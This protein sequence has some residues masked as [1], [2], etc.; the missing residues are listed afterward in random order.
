VVYDSRREHQRRV[1]RNLLFYNHYREEVKL[2]K[3]LWLGLCLIAVLILSNFVVSAK[4][5]KTVI[6]FQDW[7][8]TET[9]WLQCLK[10]VT[11]EYEKSHP[12]VE[13]Q[14][15]PVSQADKAKKFIIASEANNAPDVI[16]CEIQDIPP[17]IT[18]GYL[19]NLN[20]LIQKEKKG[21][22]DQWAE[23]PRKIGI[24]RG[25]VR[26][27]PDDAQSMVI[28]YNPEIFKAAGLDPNKPPKTWEEFREY[29]K[30][31]TNGKDQWGFG[32]VANKS[33]SLISRYFP[34][35]W[36]FGGDIF[37]A[38][39]T[40]C[41]LDSP[42]SIQAFKYFVELYTKDGVTPPAP[43]EMS[44]QDVRTFMAQKKIGMLIGSGFTISIVDALNP[45]LKAR[46]VLRVAP[47]PVGKKNVTFAQIDFWG[48]SR[49]TKIK[50]A[51]WDWIKY[52][53]SKDVQIKFFK[54][55]GVT[56]ARNDVGES[57]LIKNDKFGGVISAQIPHGKA[58]PMFIGMT[59]VNDA[60][61]VATQEAMTK[62][63]TPEA[64]MKD[65]TTKV[66][67]I[68]ARYKNN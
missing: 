8:M 48:I 51:A 65:C 58:M 66:N 21:F 56:S 20:P 34:I 7:H 15:E 23:E 49:S 6:R 5:A 41:T 50:A 31:M 37:D 54:D 17:F 52:L 45:N 18:K 44:A 2:V 11:A 13:I 14:F 57:D 33:A 3:K 9:V 12:N 26:A 27:I 63:K 61:I 22:M 25:Q 19:L 30:K 36:S 4:T 28:Y 53:T 68:I 55:N 60:I 16:H 62:Q 39:M 35:L 67:A 43:N 59:E 10:E 40:K 24:Y 64:A 1:R 32:M 46:E 29:A 42:E 47:L 38:K